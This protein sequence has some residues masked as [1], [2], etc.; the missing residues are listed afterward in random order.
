MNKNVRNVL[1]VLVIAALVALL[2]GG[3]SGANVALQAVSLAFLAALAWV[4]GIMYREH[5]VALY[6]LGDTRRAILYGA[7]AV[8]TLTLTA[9]SQMWSTAAGEIAWLAL[10]IACVYAVVAVVLRARRY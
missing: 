10:L 3:G 5:R 2:P 1:I 7:V 6:S 9:T 8:A 4:A